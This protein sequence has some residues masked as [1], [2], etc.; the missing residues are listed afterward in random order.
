MDCAPGVTTVVMFIQS[1]DAGVF[2]PSVAYSVLKL[3]AWEME[4]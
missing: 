1:V 3:Y 4:A 2:D